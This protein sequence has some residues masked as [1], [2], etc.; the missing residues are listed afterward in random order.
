MLDYIVLGSHE[1]FDSNLWISFS[2]VTPH[3]KCQRRSKRA[4]PLESQVSREILWWLSNLDKV[5]DGRF[6]RSYEKVF[7]A[8][9]L[10]IVSGAGNAQYSRVSRMVFQVTPVYSER[11]CWRH[12]RLV[13]DWYIMWVPTIKQTFL[14]KAR[15]QSSLL[16]SGDS[17]QADRIVQRRAEQSGRYA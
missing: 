5:E 17:L 6:V 12:W 4:T 8:D 3:M 2:I 1:E 7:F 15:L 13:D 11:R 14:S 10:K 16:L 9:G